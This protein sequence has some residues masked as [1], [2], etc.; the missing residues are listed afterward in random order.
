MKSE[1]MRRPAFTLVE[2][3]VVIAIIGV[4]VGLLLPAVQQAREAARSISCKNN[5]RQIG[6]ACHLY[7]DANRGYWPPAVDIGGSNNQRWFGARDSASDAYDASR[8]PLSPFFE[9]NE[10][11][12]QCPSFGNYAQGTD[13]NICN[14]NAT[15]FET[16]SGG[17][18]YNHMYVGGTWYKHGWSSPRRN[19]PSRF[20][21]IGALS[22]TVAFSDTAFTCGPGS[23]AIEYPFLE[24]PFFVNGPHPLLSAPTSWRPSPSTHFR[25]G[26]ITANIT[27]CDGRVTT[28]TM[29]GTSGGSSWYGGEPEKVRIGWFGPLDNNVVFDVRDKLDSQMGGVR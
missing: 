15:A 1:R 16:G 7:A 12:K 20:R 24:P 5:L 18:G 11:L 28:A 13:E 9:S 21:E 2:L 22:R 25:H 10:G 23:F 29:S 26:G 27:W 17:Y 19:I 6:L 4:M 14:G 3:L 8:G